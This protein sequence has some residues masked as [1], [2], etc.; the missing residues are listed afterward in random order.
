MFDEETE[1]LYSKINKIDVICFILPGA[2]EGM[3]AITF[4]SLNL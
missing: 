2:P 3:K 1:I 4:I